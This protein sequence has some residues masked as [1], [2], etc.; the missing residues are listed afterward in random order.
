MN[1]HTSAYRLAL[2]LYPARFR[3]A[4]GDEM[5][6]LFADM[7]ADQ[8]RSGRVTN[9]IRLWV[10]TLID[11]VSSATKQRMEETMKDNV[12]IT[13]TLLFAVP[14]GAAAAY[15]TV[16]VYASLVVLVAGIALLVV[17]RSSLPNALIGAGRGHWWAWTLVGL[18]LI[19]ASIGMA[20]LSN[21][22]GDELGES[23]WMLFSLLFFSG[24]LIVG[25]S[26]VRALALMMR[27]PPT[28]S[29]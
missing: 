1:S 23:G 16:G 6:R 4:Y 20:A 22:D 5:T 13:R 27:R 26:V 29:A 3:Q 10:H 11:T 21:D 8:Q 15:M 2:R 12:A 18:G 28:P 9:V 24:A 17:R 25:A 7:L 14:I 19:G